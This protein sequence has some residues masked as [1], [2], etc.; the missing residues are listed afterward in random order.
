M[1]TV[2]PLVKGFAC[3]VNG[4]EAGGVRLR[5]VWDGKDLSEGNK[6]LF[7]AGGLALAE[8]E[9]V[10]TVLH[11]ALLT[12]CPL[13]ALTLLLAAC[14]EL[15]TTADAHGRLPLHFAAE[16]RPLQT[17]ASTCRFACLKCASLPSMN[18]M[19]CTVSESTAP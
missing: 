16:V 8:D 14:P 17:D 13:E 18:A 10:A 4:V 9:P 6:R 11:L 19:K 15:A 1:P 3:E 12:G 7:R 5:R 2:G